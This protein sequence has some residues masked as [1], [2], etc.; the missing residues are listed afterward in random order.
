M[1]RCRRPVFFARPARLARRGGCYALAVGLRPAVLACAVAWT[2]ASPSAHADWQVRRSSTAPLLDAALSALWHRPDDLALARRTVQ[3]AGRAGRDALLKRLRAHAQERASYAGYESYAHVLLLLDD[4]RGAAAAFDAALHESPACSAAL[5]GRAR[6]LAAASD[7]GA[8]AAYDRALDSEHRPAARRELLEHALALLPPDPRGSDLERAVALRRE[9]ARLAPHDL[10]AAAALADLLEQ[11]GR[12]EQA[13]DALDPGAGRVPLDVALRAARLRGSSSDPAVAA[14]AAASL[15]SL[16]KQTRD[17]QQRRRIWTAARDVARARGTLADLADQLA[18]APGLAEWDQLGDVRADLGDLDGA[19]DATRRAHALDPRDV[20]IGRR[21][22]ALLD[23]TGRAP[24]ARQVEEE[25]VRRLP[26]DVQLARELAE[27]QWL[28]GDHA[29]ATATFDRALGRFAR[30]PEALQA[31]AELAGG[32]HDNARAVRA[33][34]ALGRLE[35]GD[36]VAILG[37]GEAQF[38]AG[39]RR[40]ARRTWATLRRRAASPVE[41]HL[42]LGEIL[43]DH[44]LAADAGD[45]ARAASA[46]QPRSP[47]PHRLLAR[48]AERVHQTQ[49][50]VAEWD[51]VLTLAAGTSTP[52]GTAARHEARTRLLALIANE[53]HGKLAAKIRALR[54]TVAAHPNDVESALFL[55]QAEQRAGDL[56]GAAATLRQVA[57]RSGPGAGAGDTAVEAGFALVRLL[58]HQGRLAEAEARLDQLARLVPARAREADLQAAELALARHDRAGALAR[59]NAAAA[60]ADPA[61]LAR[62]GEIREQAGDE[63]GAADAYRAAQASPDAPPTAALALARVQERQGDARAAAATLE[64]LLQASRDDA[65]VGDAA[66]RA[67]ALDELLGHLPALAESLARA[68]PDGASPPAR[69]RAL[70]DVLSRLPP[71]GSD[72]AAR[73]GWARLGRLALRPLLDILAADGDAPDRRAIDLLGRLGDGDAAPALARIAGRA[74]EKGSVRDPRHPGFVMREVAF[75]ALSALARLGDARGFD[76]L[77]RAAEDPSPSLRRIGLWGLGRIGDPRGVN[78]L[79]RALDEPQVDLQVMACL[80]LGRATDGRTAATLIRIAQDPSRARPVRRAAVAALGHLGAPAVEALLALVDGADAELA[81]EAALAAGATHD[82]RVPSA[83]VAR[84]LLPGRRGTAGAPAV[85]PALAA[86]SENADPTA[87]QAAPPADPALGTPPTTELLGAALPAPAGADPSLAW[88]SR[89]PEIARLLG[90][91]LASP[92]DGRRAAL[93]ALDSRADEPGLGELAPMGDEPISPE[94]AQ[95]TREIAAALGDAVADLLDDPER[96]VR[97]AALSVLSKLGDRRVDPR[98]VAAAVADG[99]ADLAEAAVTAARLLPRTNPAGAGAMAA[100]VTPLARDDGHGSAW[101]T[102]LTAVRVLAEL[103]P[104]GH[105]G[106]RAAAADRNPL[107]RAAARAAEARRRPDGTASGSA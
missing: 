102:R 58:K 89:V 4:P 76:V 38:Q 37:L 100:A 97:A 31:L 7:P 44:D 67:A 65:S 28:S 43:L 87:T 71:P 78:V 3:L 24:E 8:A 13:A 105:E 75:S 70:M 9:V 50:A 21:L 83:L 6:A 22:V 40:A 66:R 5:A 56:D 15:A 84:V 52:E 80:G 68:D 18:R 95:A 72:P 17:R 45:E 104:A 92:G 74:L 41:A 39:D 90:E 54:E 64:A 73:A 48:I 96:G 42:R 77:V 59:A 2:L 25:L 98:R 34:T 14:R 27:R 33:W 46:L 85:L 16:L 69:R 107:V 29:A 10:R 63:R 49:G 86:W 94:T 1:V 11:A 61:A 20:T 79:A 101:R 93:R 106:L 62:V 32:W 47:A 26:A 91:A 99:D 23:R 88:R 30:Q 36:E 57:D 51:E 35:P 82:P 60:G 53:G 103:G 55:A 81:A 12:P 19:L